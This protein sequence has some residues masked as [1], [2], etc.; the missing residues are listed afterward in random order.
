MDSHQKVLTMSSWKE[1]GCPVCRGQWES[2]SPPPEIAV[3][4]ALHAKLHRCVVCGSYWEQAERYA[5]TITLEQACV[6]FPDAEI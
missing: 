2:G 4:I 1:K 3:N 5:T 6:M